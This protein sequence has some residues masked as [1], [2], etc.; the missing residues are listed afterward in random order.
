MLPTWWHRIVIELKRV[1]YSGRGEPYRIEG[2]TLRYVPGTRPVRLRYSCSPNGIARYDALQVAWLSNHLK[3]GDTAVDV[4]A[5]HGTYSVLMAAKCGQTGRVVAI[6]PD[7]YSRDVLVKNFS[8]NPSIKRPM[9]EMCACS[10][11]IGEAILYTRGGN[12]QSSLVPSAIESPT[13]NKPEEIRV[14][15][16]TL[17]SYL[18][19]HR[20]APRCVKI[21]AEGAEIR[22]LKGA[23]QVLASNADVVCEL[24]PY[25]WPGFGN[26]FA[27]LK[28]LVAASGRHIRYLDQD[29]EIGGKAEYGIV[30]LER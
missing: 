12:S 11:R 6:E 9:V 15:I 27:E 16:V 30:L 7:P 25:A 8:L 3:E 29:V 26:T 2:H 1:L 10:D 18:S 19:E 14:P 20:L 13:A 5:H 23:K 4:G 17:D 21:D 22:I 24:H 28:I